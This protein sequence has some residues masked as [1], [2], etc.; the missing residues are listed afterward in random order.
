MTKLVTIRQRCGGRLTPLPSE[1]EASRAD[2]IKAVCDNLQIMREEL[3][4]IPALY[5]QSESE[6]PSWIDEQ[7]ST[8]NRL[9]KAMNAIAKLPEGTLLPS[10]FE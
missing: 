7:D 8:L 9:S 5:P 3:G 6:V 10:P 2:R 4:Q 1:Y